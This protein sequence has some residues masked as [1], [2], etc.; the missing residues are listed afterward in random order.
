M[1]KGINS[2]LNRRA[3]GFSDAAT[4]VVAIEDA[5]K[6]TIPWDGL[7]FSIAFKPKLKTALISTQSKV[8]ANEI[9]SARER[10][11]NTLKEGDVDISELVVR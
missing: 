8:L 6:K 10:I 3:Q 7:A 11:I 2:K 4:T 5:I 9:F 1:L